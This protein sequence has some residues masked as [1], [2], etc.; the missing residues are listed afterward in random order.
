MTTYD[1]IKIS[2]EDNRVRIEQTA[3]LG[4][5]ASH[6]MRLPLEDPEFKLLLSL[7]RLEPEGE[8]KQERE[9]ELDD[10]ISQIQSAGGFGVVA[11]R[12]G[13]MLFNTLL[14]PRSTVHDR[15]IAALDNAIRNG[16][17]LRII[18]EFRPTTTS[19]QESLL[20]LPWEYLYDSRRGFHLGCSE[21]TLLV[22]RIALPQAISPFTATL[23]LKVLVVIAEPHD[24][25]IFGREDAWRRIEEGLT[26]ASGEGAIEYRRLQRPTLRE[27]V[28]EVQS[29]N[30]H[31][32]H[33]VGHGN[34]YEGIGG[35][36]ALEDSYGAAHHVLGDSLQQAI[37]GTNT[38]AVFLTSCRSGE[39]G[40]MDDFTGVTQALVRGDIPAVISMQFS[41]P[42]VS[43]NIFCQAFYSA[44]AQRQSIDEAVNSARRVVFASADSATARDWGIPALYLQAE[45]SL[46]A[47]R[48]RRAAAAE[49]TV[50]ST[51]NNLE[52]CAHLRAANLLG[53]GKDMIEVARALR[54]PGVRRRFVTITGMGGIG[55]T[56]LAIESAYWHLERAY[57]SEGVFWFNAR[58]ATSESLVDEILTAIGVEFPTDMDID[59]TIELLHRIH[60]ERDFL[61][62]IDNTDQPR[63]DPDF[64]RFLKGLSPTPRGKFLLTA[65]RAMDID[66]EKLVTLDRISHEPAIDLFIYTWGQTKLTIEQREQ[67]AAI[68]GAGMLEGHP[69]AIYIAAA[70]ARKEGT[71]DLRPLRHRLRDNMAQVLSDQRTSEEEVSIEASLK[72]SWD[73]LRDTEQKL[74]SRISVYKAPFQEEAVSAVANELGNLTSAMTNLMEHHLVMRFGTRYY[75]HPLVQSFAGREL[76]SPVETHRRAG[77]FLIETKYLEEHLEAIDHFEMSREW[78][79]VREGVGGIINQLHL[80]G[81]WS[82]AHA[83]L[84]QGLKAAA[85][86]GDRENEGG[87]L[88]E[89]GSNYLR[90]GRFRE[91]IQYYEQALTISRE[92]GDRQGEGNRLGNLG[93]AYASLGD[94]RKA[95]EY[96]EEALTIS[97]EVGDRQGE[98]SDLGNLGLAYLLQGDNEAGLAYLLEAERIFSTVGSP[99]IDTVRGALKKLRE[100]VGQ[101]E[102][103]KLEARARK[104]LGRDEGKLK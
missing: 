81:Y 98:G 86:L 57:F 47:R 92:I 66:G 28:S 62:I 14:P 33:F 83:K 12:V 95:I 67:V 43:A 3:G 7:L 55:K 34:F 26:K 89:L 72:L 60:A 46:L 23:P 42:V 25:P 78:V 103:R 37:S 36:L 96:Y 74:L 69:F 80:Q 59:A 17:G 88:G 52:R 56:A 39:T 54:E 4:R 65:R 51:P 20:R 76:D 58:E 13:E 70:I 100:E 49:P 27:L 11:H 10:M 21:R 68:C 38:R 50:V 44:L 63:D 90:R 93:L 61:C 84:E 71:V 64:R 79:R 53:R 29:W 6:R 8:T 102:Y 22:R 35:V 91:A 85:E 31:L 75:L 18:L 101:A 77:E 87:M 45:S 19:N 15:Y 82:L 48:S 30:P 24:Q 73:S 32:L 40:P 5:T 2:L 9:D 16:K 104:R 99:D 1:T 41:V 97:R 94:V